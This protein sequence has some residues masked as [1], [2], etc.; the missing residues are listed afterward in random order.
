M[1]TIITNT[2]SKRMAN[3]REKQW[4]TDITDWSNDNLHL[5]YGEEYRDYRAIQRHHVVGR[6]Y[7]QNKTPIGHWFI[8]PIPYEMHDP[9]VDHPEH[10]A[11]CPVKFKSKYGNQRDL[12]STMIDSML[13]Q[14]YKMP[15]SEVL[16]AI[17]STHK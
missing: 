3:T 2:E 8:L 11:K 16:N 7:I 12:F 15:H 6:T 5:L 9:N 4:M 10:V 13:H 17:R 1:L 14:G